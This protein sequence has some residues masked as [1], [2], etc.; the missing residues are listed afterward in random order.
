MYPL[1]FCCLR[2]WSKEFYLT[3]NI[4]DLAVGGLFM[5]NALGN[6]GY[7]HHHYSAHVELVMDIVLF[8]VAIIALIKYLTRKWYRTGIHTAYMIVR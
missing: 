2:L 7:Q 5:F 1:L 6:K 8:V 4:I 3:V